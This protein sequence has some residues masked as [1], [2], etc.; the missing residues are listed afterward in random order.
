MCKKIYTPLTLYPLRYSRGVSD[1]TPRP[2][3][4]QNY[5]AVRSAVDVTGGKPIAVYLSLRFS[6]VNAINPIVALYDIH[7]RKRELLFLYFVPDTT[8]V[9]IYVRIIDRMP[10]INDAI[11]SASQKHMRN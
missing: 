2:T 6:G 4:Y 11:D 5:L 8:R 7:G 10:L 9:K 1:V 3:F